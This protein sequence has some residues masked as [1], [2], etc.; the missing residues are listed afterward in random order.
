M[1]RTFGLA[2]G[3][4][5]KNAAVAAAIAGF[6]V[7]WWLGALPWPLPFFAIPLA[8]AFPPVYALFFVLCA[9]PP[10]QALLSAYLTAKRISARSEPHYIAA[11]WISIGS[12]ACSCLNCYAVLRAL[13]LLED[14]GSLG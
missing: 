9:V 1:G 3:I 2:Y 11:V 14:L 6:N 4:D 5:M 12:F 13:R 8:V 7:A 10:I